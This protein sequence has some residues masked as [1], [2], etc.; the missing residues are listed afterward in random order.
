MN[1]ERVR[2]LLGE[3]RDRVEEVER[4]LDVSSGA[5]ASRRKPGPRSMRS[6]P[7]P[8]Q[9]PTYRPAQGRIPAPAAPK[10]DPLTSS[11]AKRVLAR[12]GFVETKR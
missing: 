10:S 2:E 5:P 1:P 4:E 6:A 7:S 12:N 9:P 3:I 8:R 11:V